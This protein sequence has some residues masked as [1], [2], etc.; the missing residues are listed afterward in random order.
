VAADHLPASVETPPLL[1]EELWWQMGVGSDLPYLA[2]AYV[3][4]SEPKYLDATREW[5]VASCNYV[6]PRFPGWMEIELE[7][8]NII[9]HYLPDNLRPGDALA[10]LEKIRRAQVKLSVRR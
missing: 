2:L 8:G 10:E 7:S 4:T 6:R 3:M 5:T 9:Q 1:G